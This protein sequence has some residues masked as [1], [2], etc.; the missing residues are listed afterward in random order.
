ML[1]HVTIRVA[2]LA[3]AERFY[4]TALGAM[5][6]E[7]S[8]RGADRIE[9]D[10]FHLEA[11]DAEHP[12]TRNLHVA[13]AAPS[14]D[15]V[16]EFWR[17][18]IEAGYE[19]AGAPGRR[20]QYTP[21]YYGAFLRDPDGNSAEAVH[22][23]FSESEGLV[24]HLWIRVPDLERASA[25]YA[26]VVDH[27]GLRE[28]R[29]WEEGRQF[30]G[31]RAT[32]SLVDDGAPLTEHLHLAFPAPDRRAVEEL[33]RV[34]TAIGGAGGEPPAERERAGRNRY[35]AVVFDP[36]GTSVESVWQRP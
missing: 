32:F 15:L 31:A 6:V 30:R 21:N 20:P 28:G 11:A 33:H 3:A 25:F 26:A 16:D 2:D 23:D 36:A 35:S 17:V 7:P 18:G 14:L 13:F 8:G 34:A 27:L 12:P 29:Q 5:G 10:D 1:D 24:D 4:R 19:D 9:W 22:H